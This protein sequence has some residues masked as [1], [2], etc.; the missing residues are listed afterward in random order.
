MKNCCDCYHCRVNKEVVRCD[1]GNWIKSVCNGKP[2]REI[3]KREWTGY[4]YS[5]DNDNIDNHFYKRMYNKPW[6]IEAA[7]RCLEFE[8]MGG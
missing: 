3:T 8:D 7:K 6:V 2:P 4:R 5:E 1:R